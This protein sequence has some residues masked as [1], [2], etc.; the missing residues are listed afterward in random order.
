[1]YIYYHQ[2]SINWLT[3]DLYSGKLHEAKYINLFGTY[4]SAISKSRRKQIRSCIPVS[5]MVYSFT[6]LISTSAVHRDRNKIH[7]VTHDLYVP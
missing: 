1:M 7:M 3:N 2:W 4:Q 5:F 6:K